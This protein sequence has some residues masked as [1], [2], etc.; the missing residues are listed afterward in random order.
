M[1]LFL[2]QCY[3][4]FLTLNDI[5]RSVIMR[6]N[7]HGKYYHFKKGAAEDPKLNAVLELSRSIAV[8]KGKAPSILLENEIVRLSKFILDLLGNLI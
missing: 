3:K 2:M 4:S 5:E 7:F 8:Q 1:S 6:V